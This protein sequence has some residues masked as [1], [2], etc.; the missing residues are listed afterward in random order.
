MAKAP[1]TEARNITADEILKLG[2]LYSAKELRN[3]QSKLTG[4]AREVRTLTGNRGLI[5]R[6][7]ELL[8]C[9]QRQ[10]LRDAASLVDSVNTNLEHAKEKRQ[11]DEKIAA[12]KRKERELQAKQLVRESFHLPCDTPEQMLEVI[13]LGLTINHAR[14]FQSFYSPREFSQ[15]LRQYATTPPQ[16]KPF[17]NGWSLAEELKYQA[18]YLRDTISEE[19]ADLLAY[20]GDNMSVKDKHAALQAKIEEIRGP[21][22]ELEAETLSAWS[23]AL[24]SLEKREGE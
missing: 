23:T 15:K 14:A 10:L 20:G 17:R 9:E 19:L 3:L 6:I 22:L 24:A 7:G 5:A 4:A 2:Q 12:A 8:T 16:N 11:R 1:I 21:V 13:R 18:S